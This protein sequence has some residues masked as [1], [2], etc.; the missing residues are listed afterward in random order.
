M[1]TVI[2]LGGSIVAPDK[3]DVPFLRDFLALS[4]AWLEEDP[5][6]RLILVVG[7]GGPAGTIFGCED[8]E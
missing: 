5:E 8:P 1:T 2:S 3:P 6:R 4:T 7:G